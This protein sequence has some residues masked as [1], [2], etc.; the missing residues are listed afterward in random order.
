[1]PGK[2][3]TPRGAFAF[4][5]GIEKSAGRP[6]PTPSG[7][8]SVPPT[9]SSDSSCPGDGRASHRTHL[10]RGLRVPRACVTARLFD[11]ASA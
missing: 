10:A 3:K 7:Y 8:A 11:E 9:S 2:G 6:L 1:M 4:G 5:P